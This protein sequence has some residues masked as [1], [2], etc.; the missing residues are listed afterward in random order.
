MHRVCNFQKRK[1]VKSFP[2]VDYWLSVIPVMP[3]IRQ[4]VTWFCC[5]SLP[6]L[7]SGQFDSFKG[8][9]HDEQSMKKME[10]N[11]IK[12]KQSR[13]Y[14]QGYQRTDFR[15][16]AR[17]QTK[18]IGFLAG[19]AASG[20]LDLAQ[21]QGRAGIKKQALM[22]AKV[23]DAKRELQGQRIQ[24]DKVEDYTPELAGDNLKR[25]PSTP[26]RIEPGSKVTLYQKDGKVMFY[27]TTEPLKPI[28]QA[29]PAE[30]EVLEAK[31]TEMKSEVEGLAQ[32][33]EALDSQRRQQLEQL[34]ALESL[35]KA[36]RD[37]M[38]TM[39]AEM[40][41]METMR[42]ELRVAIDK[43]RPVKDLEGVDAA[44]D[45][46]LRGQGI[47]TIEELADAKPDNLARD[48]GVNRTTIREIVRTAQLRIG[49]SQ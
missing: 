23:N 19:T 5:V 6:Q 24:V 1:Y 15:A 35:R 44:M 7:F 32:R 31:K 13:Q 11:R 34:E 49:R 17:E 12:G 42:K 9:T 38:R 37:D 30:L 33:I 39:S 20:L 48:I 26:Q 2:T 43:E 18:G 3:L 45:A 47:R 40:E 16:L 28:D 21:S 27:S 10:Q 4:A 22:G 41:R 46:K 29:G 25:Y 8:K 36:I 14:I